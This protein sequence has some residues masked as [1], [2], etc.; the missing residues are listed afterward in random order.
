MEIV[1]ALKNRQRRDLVG[2]LAERMA[3]AAPDGVD[4]V[5]WAPT[6]A[7]R[8]RRRGFDH[9]ELL[10]RAIARR[11]GLP[12]SR[13][14]VRRGSTPQAGLDAGARRGNPRFV[15]SGCGGRSVLVVDDVTTTGATLEAAGRALLVAGATAVHGL[16]VARAAGPTAPVSTPRARSTAQA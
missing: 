5:T 16:V 6:G 1:T 7:P 4:V 2:W 11:R 12:S 10:A 15:A 14:L 8:R 3:P 9:A 13:L